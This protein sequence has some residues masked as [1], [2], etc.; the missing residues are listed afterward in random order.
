MQR[1]GGGTSRLLMLE[2]FEVA[3]SRS[4]HGL[5][6]AAHHLT[7]GKGP[8]DPVEPPAAYGLRDAANRFR[9]K[10]DHVGI[11]PKEGDSA[12][13]RRN[14]HDVPTHDRTAS[15]GSV[16]PM[17]HGAPCKMAAQPDQREPLRN[18]QCFAIPMANRGIG[19][20]DPF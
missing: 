13:V 17:K 18:L 14:L 12:E 5:A 11:A 6:A 15:L 3:C 2:A 19:T 8:V 16:R 1:P 20:H 10:R 4:L 9:R 7:S